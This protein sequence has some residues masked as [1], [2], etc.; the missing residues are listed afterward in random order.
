MR[1]SCGSQPSGKESPVGDK[2]GK[3]DKE[4]NRK[5]KEKKKADQAQ[6][7]REKNHKPTV[8]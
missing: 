4:R 8:A 3:K 1:G 5:Q 7:K 6:A 2:G